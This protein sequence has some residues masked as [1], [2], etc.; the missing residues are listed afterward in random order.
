MSTGERVTG[1]HARCY[2]SA[3]RRVVAVAGLEL[4]AER[5]A[6]RRSGLATSEALSKAR[7]ILQDALDCG[8]RLAAV[9]LAHETELTKAML[10][11]IRE[12]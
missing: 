5:V 10:A 4:D 7:V 2:R 6:A 12:E 1:I 3:L 9:R 11:D 8:D